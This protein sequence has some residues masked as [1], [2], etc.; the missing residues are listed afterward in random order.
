MLVNTLS[1]DFLF[2]F[3]E[4]QWSAHRLSHDFEKNSV[5][6]KVS[7]IRIGVFV[8]TGPQVEFGHRGGEDASLLLCVCVLYTEP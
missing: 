8:R 7:S 3:R 5:V 1:V 4:V 6:R 2:G